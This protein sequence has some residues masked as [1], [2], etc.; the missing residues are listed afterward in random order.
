MKKWWMLVLA[1]LMLAACSN[2]EQ[3]TTNPEENDES[4]VGF[5]VM[6]DKVEEAPNV[7]EEQEEQILSAFSEYIDSFNAKD[8]DRYIET[9]SKDP[10]GFDY[11]E[12]LQY[13]KEMFEK[14]DITK[15]IK[16]VTIVKYSPEEAQIFSNMETVVKEI[17]TSVINKETRRQVTVFKNE[18]GDWK[19]TSV[20]AMGDLQ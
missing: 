12:E 6:G 9:L 3:V 8:I 18:N 1:A 11:E 15:S 5:E 2:K 7:P 4:T 16:D 14:Y 10:Q 20:F 13:T 19:V 17:E